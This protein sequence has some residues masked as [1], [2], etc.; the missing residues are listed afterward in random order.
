MSTGKPNAKSRFSRLLKRVSTSSFRKSKSRQAE[1]ITDAFSLASEDRVRSGSSSSNATAA[2]AS[3]PSQAA[4]G[5]PIHT[6]AAS[7]AV[8]SPFPVARSASEPSR[9]SVPRSGT[10]SSKRTVRSRL[11][12]SV[13]PERGPEEAASPSGHSQSHSDSPVADTNR[14]MEQESLIARFKSQIEV[15]LLGV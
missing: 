10:V 15:C 4:P 6:A 7:H 11:L 9:D 8:A 5:G 2:V 3:Q 12:A 13:I 14:L 1:D